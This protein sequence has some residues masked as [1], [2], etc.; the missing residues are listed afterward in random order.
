MRPRNTSVSP[1]VDMCLLLLLLPAMLLCITVK[2]ERQRKQLSRVFS[3][4]GVAGNVF[5]SLNL[6][7]YCFFFFA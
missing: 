2:A 7:I 1:S 3:V 4:R 6:H 5:P